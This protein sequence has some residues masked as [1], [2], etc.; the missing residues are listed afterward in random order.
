MQS[1]RDNGNIYGKNSILLLERINLI[2]NSSTDE[3]RKHVR[4]P[5]DSPQSEYNSK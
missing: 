2:D 4:P 5:Q 3:L 1:Y